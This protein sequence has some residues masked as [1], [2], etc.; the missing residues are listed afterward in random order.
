MN[1]RVSQA[2]PSHSLQ[3]TESRRP[4]AWGRLFSLAVIAN[5]AA[6]VCAV[7][8]AR[9]LRAIPETDSGEQWLR[10]A[11]YI[12]V[13]IAAI[14]DAFLLDEVLFKGAF[15]RSQLFGKVPGFARRDE[16]VED[17][18]VSLQKT[19]W[20]F[21]F[22][23][24]SSG[25]VT[26]IVLNFVTR[27]IDGYYKTLGIHIGAIERGDP[28]RQKEGVRQLSL[29]RSPEVLP[30]LRRALGKGGEVAAWSAW[31]IGRH[32]DVQNRRPLIAPLVTAV[33]EGDPALRR[34]AAIALG[35]LQQ[36]SMVGA[37][38]DE[39]RAD[40]EGGEGIDVRLLYALGAVQVTSSKDLLAQVLE[41]GDPLAQR[42]A[43][44]AIAQH[45]DQRGGKDFGRLLED[46]LV[47][48]DVELRCAIVH[49]L[50]IFAHERSNLAL[51]R[52]YDDSTEAEL[53]FG[54]PRISI[55]MSPDGKE[56]FEEIL[57]PEDN[58]ALK[59][60]ASMGQMRA[61]TP[62]IRAVVEPWLQARV[63]DTTAT[64]FIQEGART[65]LAGIREARNDATKP[66]VEEALDHDR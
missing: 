33:R 41:R 49:A 44:W 9:L 35:R 36:R 18:A 62:E 47:T 60:I 53:A 65:L 46:R 14:F 17:V 6:L 59:I 56:D 64:L 43:A 57:M 2:D 28:E 61:T 12:G 39:L 58:L 50:G 25:L 5:A 34:E 22:L 40:L 42:I 11:H 32:R 4:A 20:S 55:P 24:I 13:G 1:G 10:A 31:A 26:M 37:L 15:R 21:P 38:Q 54:C 30:T 29:R 63:D 16:D 52:A 8:A 19:T 66:T 3:V 27:D 45:R 51:V 23:L 7:W 48:A